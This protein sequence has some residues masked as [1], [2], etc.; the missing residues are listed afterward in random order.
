MLTWKIGREVMYRFKTGYWFKK[1]KSAWFKEDGKIRFR[2]F[3]P[4]CVQIF[5]QMGYIFLM[6]F[7]WNYA[8]EAGINQGVITVVVFFTAIGNCVSFYCFFGEKISKLHVIG[9]I[10]LLLGL[11]CIGVSA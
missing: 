9:L 7:A 11:V 4:M 5:G 3:I 2:S 1:E 6:T 8:A 10:C